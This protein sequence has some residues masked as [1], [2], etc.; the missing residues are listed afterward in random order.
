MTA[1]SQGHPGWVYNH[2]TS[3]RF[4]SAC[5]ACLHPETFT[6]P[7]ISEPAKSNSADSSATSTPSLSLNSQ[8]PPTLSDDDDDKMSVGPESTSITETDPPIQYS[9]YM[10]IDHPVMSIRSSI[11]VPEN[12]TEYLLN[13]TVMNYPS[14]VDAEFLSL[15]RDTSRCRLSKV[16]L[17]GSDINS[18][19]LQYL[20]NHNIKSL[21]LR[22]CDKLFSDSWMEVDE[23]CKNLVSLAVSRNIVPDESK[24]WRLALPC[25]QEFIMTNVEAQSSFFSSLF[26]SFGSN[27]THLNLSDCQKIENLQAISHLRLTSLLLYN[28][29]YP[30]EAIAS[31]CEIESLR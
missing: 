9:S 2:P 30:D 6:S 22:D 14:R 10:E 31:I 17:R 5:Q 19:S 3:L 20:L 23:K 28:S 26:N 7:L 18:H 15:F 11:Y 21:D 8:F 13:T 27:L 4:L 29:L 16:N 25:L 24:R 12:I 1:G